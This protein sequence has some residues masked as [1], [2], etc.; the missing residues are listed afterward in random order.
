MRGPE[1]RLSESTL[2]VAAIPVTRMLRVPRVV[3]TRAR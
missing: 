2:L 1:Y 3:A